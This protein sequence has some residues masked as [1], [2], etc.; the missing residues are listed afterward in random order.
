VTRARQAR[1]VSLRAVITGAL[2]LC[3]AIAVAVGVATVYGHHLAPE[4][5]PGTAAQRGPLP[6]SQSAPQTERER[7]E[8]AQRARLEGWGWIDRQAG[9]AHIP[10]TRAMALMVAPPQGRQSP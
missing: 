5:A 3:A 4:R 1:A 2:A 7:H 8:A 9:I 10:V 6:L